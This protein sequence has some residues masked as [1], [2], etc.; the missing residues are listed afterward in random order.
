MVGSGKIL[1][2]IIIICIVS[3]LALNWVG[4]LFVIAVLSIIALL[5][6]F[7]HHVSKEVKEHDNNKKQ[8]AQMNHDTQKS[9]EIHD[10]D[11]ALNYE[12]Q[13]NCRQLGY[14]TEKMW[15]DKLPN[16]VNKSY[17]TS[18]EDITGKFAQ[19]IEQQSIRQNSDWFQPFINYLVDHPQ[20]ATV[21]KMLQEV[22]CLQLKYTHRTPNNI[23]LK[24]YLLKGTERI[25]KDVPPI[26]NMTPVE[27]VGEIFKL[28][29]YGQRQYGGRTSAQEEKRTEEIDFND[30]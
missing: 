8:I 4:V 27:G 25:Q 16:Y 18:F 15:K 20:G 13:K 30:L 7:G 12:L 11:A 3:F 9:K 17:S 23:M 5:R 22:N 26:F 29:T 21:I 28:S 19:Q 1:F 2:F 24:A 6:S 10:N 14:M